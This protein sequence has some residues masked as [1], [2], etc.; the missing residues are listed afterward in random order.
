MQSLN[1]QWM[2]ATD[3]ENVGQEKRWFEEGPIEYAQNSTV[4]GIIQQ[5]FPGYHGVVWYWRTFTP[6]LTPG[7]SP[8]TPHPNVEGVV[9][10]GRYLLRF[11]GVDYLAD[12]WLNGIYVGGHEGGETPFVLNVTDAIKLGVENLLAVRVL[13]PTN[14]PIEGIT[15][16][17]KPHRNKVLP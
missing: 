16:K 13:N 17:Q 10:R 1:G 5:T 6:A 12:V 8:Q 11:W 9:E 3:P 14:E 4:P 7:P 2:L 15:L